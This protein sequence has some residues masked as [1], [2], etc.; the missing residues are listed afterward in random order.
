MAYELRLG[1]CLP[2]LADMPPASVDAIIT[3]VP[4]GTTNCAWD[5]VIPFE[6]MWER[7]KRVLKSGCVFITASA[8]PFASALV[9]SNIKW[10]RQELIWAKNCPRGFLDAKRKHL[11]SH[12]NILIF[13]DGRHK[14][15]PQMSVA[16]K[17]RI[18]RRGDIPEHY[19]RGIE[20]LST[21]NLGLSYPRSVLEYGVE[22]GL[23]P[24]QKPLAL[25]EYLI[26]TYT[27]PG[28][29]VLDFC[30]G[31]GTTGEAAIKHGRN[32]IGIEQDPRYF[33][34]A[35]RRIAQA[36]AQLPLLP[37]AQAVRFEQSGF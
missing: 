13:S 10:F 30:M 14:Y 2:R 24:T 31:S 8:Q 9:M 33:A 11:K 34:I 7:V 32:F 20:R 26:L 18:V 1:D 6:P 37:Q 19:G 5:V 4:Y 15:N 27:D 35:E 21:D 3:D 12:E 22:V 16:E 36:A 29:A 28:D 25:Y 23:H 17:R